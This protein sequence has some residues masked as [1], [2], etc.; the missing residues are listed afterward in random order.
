MVISDRGDRQHRLMHTHVAS[1]SVNPRGDHMELSYRWS[2]AESENQSG[3]LGI[4]LGYTCTQYPSDSESLSQRFVN[5]SQLSGDTA[6][7]WAVILYA[8]K[9]E[10]L[11]QC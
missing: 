7:R 9:Y 4:A 1:T 5:A 2:C 10:A 6:R 11:L 8:T 3:R